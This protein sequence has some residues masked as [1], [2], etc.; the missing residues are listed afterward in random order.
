MQTQSKVGNN[1]RH[2]K[3]DEIIQCANFSIFKSLLYLLSVVEVTNCRFLPPCISSVLCYFT[4]SFISP[5][6]LLYLFLLKWVPIAEFRLH[7]LRT[8]GYMVHY[9]H[10]LSVYMCMRVCVSVQMCVRLCLCVWLCHWPCVWT[11]HAHAC[12]ILCV[13]VY[14]SV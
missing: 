10:A 13:Q 1:R 8:D 4:L 11:S 5:F 9:G 6:F 7:L 2:E 3:T 12:I 14:V